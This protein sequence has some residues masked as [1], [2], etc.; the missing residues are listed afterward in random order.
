MK[1]TYKNDPHHS[2]FDMAA[3]KKIDLTLTWSIQ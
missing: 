3:A 2:P 1:V